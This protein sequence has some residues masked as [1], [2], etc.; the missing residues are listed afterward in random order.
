[1]VESQVRPN[2]VTDGALLAALRRI[3]REKFLPSQLQDRAYMDED[4][5]LGNGRYLPEPV[6]PARLLQA[7]R[8]QKTD[9]ALDIGSGTGYTTALLGSLCGYVTGIEQDQKMAA[10]AAGLLNQLGISNAAVLQQDGL[11]QGYAKKSPYN[12]ILINGAVAM[13]PENIK[14]QLAEGGRLVTIISRRGHIGTA[15]IITRHGNNFVT[16]NLFEAATPFLPGFED[17]KAFVF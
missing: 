16:Q 7:A 11:H 2:K 15:V 8:V 14:S 4:I 9:A 5:A 1:M 12:V 13:V 10:T 17:P 6:I 3:P